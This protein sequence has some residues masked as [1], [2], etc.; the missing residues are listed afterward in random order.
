MS[1][2]YTVSTIEIEQM[3]SIHDESV[4]FNEFTNQYDFFDMFIMV[5]H[6]EGFRNVCDMSYNELLTGIEDEPYWANSESTATA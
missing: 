4:D 2:C 3:E 1:N 6:N 5:S